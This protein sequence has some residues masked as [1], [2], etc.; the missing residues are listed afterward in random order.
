MYVAAHEITV[1]SACAK[2]HPLYMHAQLSNEGRGLIVG[3]MFHSF[4]H[5]AVGNMSGNRCESDCRSRGGE[6][7]PGPVPYFRA[8]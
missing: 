1:L 6:F 5:S 7:Y 3:L 4:P 2:I 8:D